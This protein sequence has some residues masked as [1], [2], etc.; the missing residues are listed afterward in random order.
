MFTPPS[1]PKPPL[2]QGDPEPR[3]DVDYESDDEPPFSYPEDIRKHALGRKMTW[4]VV[5]LPLFLIVVTLITRFFTHPAMLDVLSNPDWRSS[6]W[7]TTGG[8]WTRHKRHPDNGPVPPPS[9]SPLPPPPALTTTA[10]LSG[11]A[12]ESSTSSSLVVF[13]TQP[14]SISS[15]TSSTRPST[16]TSQRLPTVPTGTIDV[17]TPFPVP[18]DTSFQQNFSSVSCYN[19]FLNMTNSIS[20]RSCRPFSLLLQRSNAFIEV[21]VR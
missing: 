16:T 21:S 1:S 3:F 9:P 11:R 13:P 17:P 15:S 4:A 12:P 18:F 6:S 5:L 10:T 8:G 7:R 20:F 14:I 19:F 2:K